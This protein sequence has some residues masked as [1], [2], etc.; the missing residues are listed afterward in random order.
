[1][2][3]L[4]GLIVKHCGL[5]ENHKPQFKNRCIKRVKWGSSQSV[6]TSTFTSYIRPV[7]DYSFELLVT[8]S[9]SALPKLGIVQN[10]ALGF[11]TSAA[12]STPIAA[13]QLQSEIFGSSG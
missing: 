8:A 1:M 4:R 5:P 10:K 9:D 6:L 2:R 11:I 13:M 12:T 7:I 3:D